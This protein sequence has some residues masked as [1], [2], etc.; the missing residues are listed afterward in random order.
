VQGSCALRLAFY[1]GF[2]PRNLLVNSSQ[3]LLIN[4]HGMNLQLAELAAKHYHM[5]MAEQTKISVTDALR[6]QQEQ[7]KRLVLQTAWIGDAPTATLQEIQAQ[8]AELR[9]LIDQLE[10]AIQRQL[11]KEPNA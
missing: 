2:Y 8:M 11:K 10:Q 3:E 4:G 5:R 9:R 6:G 7:L 1:S